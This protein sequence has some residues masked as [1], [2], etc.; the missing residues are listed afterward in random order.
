MLHFNTRVVTQPICLSSFQLRDPEPPQYARRQQYVHPQRVQTHLTRRKQRHG[1]CTCEAQSLVDA[2]GGQPAPQRA[3]WNDHQELWAAVHS[4]EELDQELQGN[5]KDLVVIGEPACHDHYV[6]RKH[7]FLQLF[8]VQ[9]FLFAAFPVSACFS[10]Q[11][12][13]VSALMAIPN[14]AQLQS[15]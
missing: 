8:L 10:S 13:L 9:L 11:C 12:L 6:V 2:L 14:T 4:P 3:W 7:F 5:G 15:D 1:C